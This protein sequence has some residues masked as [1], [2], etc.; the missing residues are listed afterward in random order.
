M[1]IICSTMGLK[2]VNFSKRRFLGGKNREKISHSP[3][4]GGRGG[5]VYTLSK[6]G[7]KN[8]LPGTK[9]FPAEDYLLILN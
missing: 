3:A 1:A 8:S 5:I 7:G 4:G 6:Y 9:I 2:G